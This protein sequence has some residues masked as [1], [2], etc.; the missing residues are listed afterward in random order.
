MLPILNVP[1]IVVQVPTVSE[2]LTYPLTKRAI[3]SSPFSKSR[4]HPITGIPRPHYGIDLVADQ[5]E[6]ILAAHSGKVVLAESYGGYGNTVMIEGEGVRTL[7]A[8]ASKLYVSKGQSVNAGDTIAEVGSTGF[9][10]GPHL[11]FEVHRKINGA[12]IPIDPAPAL[13]L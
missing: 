13:S 11:H 4:I 3:V 2:V 9:S 12:W 7:Y 5:G 6:P 1:A 10:T 8:H